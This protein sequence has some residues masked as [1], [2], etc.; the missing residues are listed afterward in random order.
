MSVLRGVW[1][2]VAT[3]FDEAERVDYESLRTQIEALAAGGCHGAILFGFAS[4]FYALTDDERDEIVRVSVETANRVEIPL[5]AS[6]THQATTVAVE[7]AAAD[8]SAGVDG[9]MLLPPFVTNPGADGVRKHV[10]AVCETVSI[11]VLV[12]YAP[13]LTGVTVAPDTLADLATSIPNLVGYKIECTPPGGYISDLLERTEDIDVL[14]GNAGRVYVE[15]LER[16]ATGVVPGGSLH[17]CYLEIYNHHRAGELERAIE[18]HTELL[19]LIEHIGQTIE[20]FIHYEKRMQADRGF[21]ADPRPRSPGFIPDRY[22]DRLF[23][24]LYEPL[25]ARCDRLAGE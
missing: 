11:P 17:E 9:L 15:A 13:E 14:V 5:Y 10:A 22:D 18:R 6:V 7:Q 4:E 24:R 23:E 8:E 16:G 2:I 19:G 12:Q 3:P 20:M 21:I 25:R 1:P